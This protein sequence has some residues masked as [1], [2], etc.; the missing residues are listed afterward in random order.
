MSN[1]VSCNH[2]DKYG[3][4]CRCRQLHEWGLYSSYL[5][6]RI[7]NYRLVRY[8][9]RILNIKW[10]KSL[11]G[12]SNFKSRICVPKDMWVNREMKQKYFK[13]ILI[14]SSTTRS[15]Q[16]L[17]DL[18]VICSKKTEFHS[19]RMGG[20]GNPGALKGLMRVH[21]LFLFLLFTTG[22]SSRIKCSSY[23]VIQSCSPAQSMSW[24]RK[25]LF[26]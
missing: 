12:I 22:A 3:D 16:G 8:G 23:W 6:I 7:L 13:C 1:S 2:W 26:L 17:F 11:Q 24:R 25:A 20:E 15:I 18:Y 10:H 4:L 9:E 14:H 5:R 21:S 19:V